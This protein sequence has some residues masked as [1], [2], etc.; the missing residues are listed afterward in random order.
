MTE[1]TPV[2]GLSES[3]INQATPPIGLNGA[4]VPTYWN[5]KRCSDEPEIDY[6]D[7]WETLSQQDT[8]CARFESG[9]GGHFVMRDGVCLAVYAGPHGP[10]NRATPIDEMNLKRLFQHSDRIDFLPLKE[11]PFNNIVVEPSVEREGN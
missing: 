4:P 6:Q 9:S 8:L 11:S 3:G 1:G 5:I 10:E 7:L 2:V